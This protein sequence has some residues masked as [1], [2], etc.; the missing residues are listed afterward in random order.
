MVKSLGLNFFIIQGLRLKVTFVTF[1][2]ILNFVPHVWAQR[3]GEY[4]SVE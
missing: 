4:A 3:R 1:N 2:W